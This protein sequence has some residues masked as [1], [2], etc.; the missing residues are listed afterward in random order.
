MVRLALTLPLTILVASCGVAQIGLH[1]INVPIESRK[2]VADA[3][4]A[5]S[6]ARARLDDAN[7]RL[8]EVQDW[9][10]VVVDD[11]GWPADPGAAGKLDA[12]ADGRIEL[13]KLELE[14]AETSLNLS[15]AK[16]DL[17]NAQTALRH[18]LAT[19]DLKPLRED[20]EEWLAK[21]KALKGTIEA[22]RGQ[23]EKL[24]KDWWAT[25][26]S[27]VKGGGKSKDFYTA[28]APK[29]K[30]RKRRIKKKEKVVPKAPEDAKNPADDL[31][32]K[33]DKAA[34]APAPAATKPQ[35]K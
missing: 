12:L 25:Y 6:I 26:A 14:A 35:P 28:G 8:K 32:K 9:R 11:S 3:Q 17:V 5:V 34:P 15:L 2:L 22:K 24:T 21:L 30:V 20:A 16:L 27:F 33:K 13:A 18:D 7:G 29:V 4:D 23:V 31:L 1:D 10:K 19:Y